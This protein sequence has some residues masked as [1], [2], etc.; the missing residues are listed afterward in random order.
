M[1]PY[2]TSNN[3]SISSDENKLN[4]ETNIGNRKGIGQTLRCL[5]KSVRKLR[6]MRRNICLDKS[7]E[8]HAHSN[9][10]SECQKRSRADLSYEHKEIYPISNKKKSTYTLSSSNGNNL[11][12]KSSTLLPNVSVQ[13]NPIL[14]KETHVDIIGRRS[15]NGFNISVENTWRKALEELMIKE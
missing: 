1:Q 15:F 6:F 14:S 2:T 3:E 12:I 9:S 5:S 13:D 8:Y 4:I 11:D 7:K 10:R